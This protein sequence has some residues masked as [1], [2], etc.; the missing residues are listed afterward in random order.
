MHAGSESIAVKSDAALAERYRS[1]RQQTHSICAPLEREDYVIQS[2][3]DVS[4][5]KWHLAHTTWFFEVFV[6]KQYA[7]GYALKD[8]RYPFLFNSYYIQAGDRWSRPHRG[9]LSRPT[10]EDVFAYRSHVDDAMETFL[11]GEVSDEARAVLE[12]GL[13]HEQQHQELMVTDIKHVLS[14]N[15]LYPAYHRH[16]VPPGRSAPALDMIPFDAAVTE[17]GYQ[18]DAFSYDNEGPR[19]RQF[20]EA[21]E[22]ASRPVTNGEYLSFIEEDGYSRSPLWLS[23]GWDLVQKENWGRPIYWLQQDG[24]WFE[25]TL[26]GL[27][28]LDLQAPLTHI[29]Y[30]EADAYARW[31]GCRLPTEFEWEHASAGRSMAG[32]YSDDRV[33]HASWPDGNAGVSDSS[34]DGAGDGAQARA[35]AAELHALFGTSWEW[36]SSHYSPYPGYKPV[37]GALG[38]YNGKFMANQFVLK[39]GSCATPSN[40][41]RRTYRNFFPSNAR[42]QF[43]GIRL[44]RTP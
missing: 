21:F 3:E 7:P 8:E 12:I 5:T 25:F 15:P 39:G 10:V 35:G 1:I 22:L 30:F 17:I 20:V 43:T 2:M 24:G 14:V 28:P 4:P 41:I 38:E 13:H 26:Y 40:H 34:G 37:D 19:H 29:S 44:A 36:T 42:W 18:G 33:F 16:E 23:Q 32:Q 6:L 27:Q 31:K 9:I 11:T